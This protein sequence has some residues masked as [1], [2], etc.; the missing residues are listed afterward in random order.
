MKKVASLSFLLCAFMLASPVGAAP[1]QPIIFLVRH[2]EKAADG[3]A[4]DPDL[5][6]VG[7]ARAAALA[8]LLKNADI[9]AVYATEFKRTQ[10]TAT[11]TA[12]AAG[13]KVKQISGDKIS[14]LVAKLHAQHGNALVVGHSNTLP[15]I[16]KALGL[17]EAGAIADADYDN[18][19]VVFPGSTPRLVH[20][21]YR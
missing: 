3:D 6:D 16:I 18:L 14:T 2:A 17:P 10:Q 5:S 12:E 13:L 1:A 15:Q 8:Q 11:P 21:R 20:L 19:F 9:R 4:K 7:R